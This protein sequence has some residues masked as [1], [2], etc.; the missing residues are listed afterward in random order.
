MLIERYAEGEDTRH[1]KQQN[2]QTYGELDQRLAPLTTAKVRSTARPGK[3]FHV[4]HIGIGQLHLEWRAPPSRRHAKL[5]YPRRVSRN[6]R[7]YALV[8][9]L[10]W[11]EFPRS[12]CGNLQS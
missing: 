12:T 3:D 7:A 9:D 1:Q 4:W 11:T 2:R 5:R 6:P 10:Q 8:V